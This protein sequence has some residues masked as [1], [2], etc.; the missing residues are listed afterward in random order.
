MAERTAEPQRTQQPSHQSRTWGE[1]GG[2]TPVI[3][4][5]REGERGRET[6]VTQLDRE[7]ERERE[8][9]RDAERERDGESKLVT[10]YYY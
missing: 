3:H 7:R 9:E 4:Q 8:R 10:N 2:E 5:V 1:R 6:H